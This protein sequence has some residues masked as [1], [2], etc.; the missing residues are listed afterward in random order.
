MLRRRE[1]A[2]GR[3]PVGERAAVAA[4]GRGRRAEGAPGR[5]LERAG[6]AEVE[7]RREVDVDA[8]AAQVARRRD[9]LGAHGRGVAASPPSPPPSATARPDRR[10]TSPPSWSIITSSGR[11]RRAAGPRL[12]SACRRAVSARSCAR[13]AML[14][15]NRITPATSPRRTC[16][17]ERVRAR[18]CPAARR[19]SAGRRPARASAADAVVAGPGA[20]PPAAANTATASSDA[21][22][23]GGARVG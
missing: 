18:S 9:A 10:F 11:S 1:H 21:S 7:H 5:A 15:L 6:Q 13:E 19:R 2:A 3:E 14:R 4:H 23:R 17:R 8:D 20:P 12:R 22:M 16:P